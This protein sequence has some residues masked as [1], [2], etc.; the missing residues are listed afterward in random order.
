MPALSFQRP[1]RIIYQQQ[2]TW[3]AAKPPAAAASAAQQ[4]EANCTSQG[5]DE[6]RNGSEDPA[7]G[8]GDGRTQ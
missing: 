6:P 1:N 7:I 2:R 8:T 4:D 3:N 5:H